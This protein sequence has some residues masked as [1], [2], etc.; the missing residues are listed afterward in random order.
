[1]LQ[2]LNKKYFISEEQQEERMKYCRK[3]DY[4]IASTTMCGKCFCYLPWKIQLA[5]ASCP[6]K[7]WLNIT[8]NETVN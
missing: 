8:I 2:E 5:P 1:M 4:F 7:K 3:C 6:E